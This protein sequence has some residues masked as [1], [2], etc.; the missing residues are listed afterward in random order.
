MAMSELVNA[1]ALGPSRPADVLTLVYQHRLLTTRQI[2]LMHRPEGSLRSAQRVMSGLRASGLAK[3]GRSAVTDEA[4]WYLTDEGAAVAESGARARARRYRMTAA[5]VNGPLRGHTLAVNEVGLAFMTA[6]RRRGDE[7]GPSDWEHEVA[8]RITDRRAAGQSKKDLCIPD[9]VLHYTRC[10]AHGQELLARCI[11]VDR[12]NETVEKLADK[13][14]VY[15]KLHGYRPRQPAGPVPGGWRGQFLVF[16][17]ILVVFCGRSES[18][19]AS[20][21]N[22]L[23]A[24]VALDPVMKRAGCPSDGKDPVVVM[25]TTLPELV[26]RGPF[27][28]IFWTP[29]VDHAVD[30][31][32]DE[33]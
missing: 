19:M 5:L 14:R 31:V 23:L 26:E 30:V 24:R 13:L 8:F 10:W 28:P 18:A 25:V 17:K 15:V 7:F 4:V 22:T 27:A 32:G 33:L 2:H 12:C 9:A 11:E 1:T 6:A 20:R 3:C 29:G 21:R 16:P